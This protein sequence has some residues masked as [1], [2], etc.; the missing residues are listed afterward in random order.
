MG[1]LGARIA[2]HVEETRVV[3]GTNVFYACVVGAKQPVYDP[4]SRQAA[5]IGHYPYSQVLSKDGK[6]HGI[7][8]K[9]TFYNESIDA[10]AIQTRSGRKSLIVT[11]DHLILAW[12]N[13]KIIWVP[14]KNLKDTDYVFGKRSHNAI[15][16]GSNKTSFLCFCGTIFETL[17]DILPFRHP[18]YCSSECRHKYSSHALSTGMHWE[19]SEKAK[20]KH[21]GPNNPAWRGGIG[22][23]P[24]D[25]NFNGSLKA[26]VLERD[27][28]QCQLC[29][30]SSDLIVHHKD[31]DKMNSAINNLITLCRQCH[32]RLRR[33]DC[34]LPEVNQHIFVPK[35]ILSIRRE[36]ITRQGKSNIPRL[37]D[38]TIHNEN[39][40]VV[41]GVL[42]HNSF[43][44]FGTKPHFPPPSALATWARRHGFGPRGEWA[45]A[46]AI[47]KRGTK[48][49]P[50]LVPAL[51]ESKPDIEGFLRD[52][53]RQ[54]EA[55]W[56][57]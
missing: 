15:T 7:V 41:S 39:S 22:L 30:I 38:F 1:F 25:W 53:A 3:I 17:N 24:Y 19:L 42:V 18:K 40:F 16:D 23:L 8:Q 28:N 56:G 46:R 33:Q 36:C 20:E 35:P 54:I 37:Y 12:R 32:G 13:G 48:A 31:W 34:E 47:A 55:K 51:L 10:V 2:P 44:E 9:H 5:G 52:A 11:S 29:H 6:P 45:L 50:F 14:A 43:V 21:R 57:K 4:L 26:Q 49:R 27:N